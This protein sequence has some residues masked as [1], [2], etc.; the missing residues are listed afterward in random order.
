MHA[1]HGSGIVFPEILFE[2]TRFEHRELFGKNTYAWEAL[3]ELKEYITR[4]LA[5]ASPSPSAHVMEG[6]VV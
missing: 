6:A 3:L 4:K 1:G 2:L 5:Q